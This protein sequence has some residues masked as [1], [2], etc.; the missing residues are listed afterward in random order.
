MKCTHYLIV[1]EVSYMQLQISPKAISR[2][3]LRLPIR[4]NSQNEQSQDEQLSV[5]S[6]IALY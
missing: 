5:T 6:V 4:P 3:L 1:F 2:G